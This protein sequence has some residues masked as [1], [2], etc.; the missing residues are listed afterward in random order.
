VRLTHGANVTVRSQTQLGRISWP[1][2]S[3]ATLD[4]YVV[5]NGSAQL[6][7]GVVMG[8]VVIKVDD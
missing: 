2:D 4:E 1:G 6:E 8:R 5:G 7:I 3:Q